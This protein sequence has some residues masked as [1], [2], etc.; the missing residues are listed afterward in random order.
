DGVALSVH[1]RAN[2]MKT[3]APHELLGPVPAG[4]PIPEAHRCLRDAHRLWHD[5]AGHYHDPEGFRAYLNSTIEALRSVTFRVQREKAA[6]PG[7][8]A[9]YE[10][11]RVRMKEDLVL[12]WLNEARVEV[13][14]RGDLETASTARASILTWAEHR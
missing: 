8:D 5:A 12:R 13:F 1:D 9:W 4:C 3:P 10:T 7:F 11:W 6:I 2:V 14:H